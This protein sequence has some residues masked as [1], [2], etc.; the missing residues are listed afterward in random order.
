VADYNIKNRED[1]ELSLRHSTFR[2]QSEASGQFFNRVL[3]TRKQTSLMN[4]SIYRVA[5]FQNM[6][7]H[8]DEE[9]KQRIQL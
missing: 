6:S 4:T 5:T 7:V 2:D 8:D 1:V 9:E 3:D